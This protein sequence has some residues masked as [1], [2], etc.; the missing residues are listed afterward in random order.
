MTIYGEG[1]IKFR[2]HCEALEVDTTFPRD[3]AVE[4]LDRYIRS[5]RRDITVLEEARAEAI[6][7]GAV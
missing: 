5:L 2:F 3:G 1:D 7:R 4:R 6:R